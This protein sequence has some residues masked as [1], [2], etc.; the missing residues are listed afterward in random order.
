MATLRLRTV[1][2][3]ASVLLALTAGTLG[4]GP[5]PSRRPPAPQELDL[6]VS[7]ERPVGS[8]GPLLPP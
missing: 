5:S 8:P 1:A 3:A 7:E 2:G 4:C 6:E